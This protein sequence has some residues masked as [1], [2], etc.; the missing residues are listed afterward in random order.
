MNTL[1]KPLLIVLLIGGCTAAKIEKQFNKDQFQIIIDRYGKRISKNSANESFYVAEAYRKSNRIENSAV[2]Y[3][4]AISKGIANESAYIF[5]AKSLKAQEKYDEGKKVI[6]DYLK[7]GQDSVYLD[8]ARRELS[9]LHV[10]DTLIERKTFFR[11]KN[12]EDI[13]T[14]YAEYS[15]VYLKNKLH[16]VSNRG[17]D[18][19]Y[20]SLGVP[21][22]DIFEVE[23]KGAL[24]NKKSLKPM[25][26]VI[27]HPNANEGSMT[28]S[29]D[30]R[31]MIFAKGNTGKSRDVDEVYLYFTRFRNGKWSK[32]KP[33]AVNEPKTWNSCPSLSPN[34]KTLYF[35]SNRIG[36]YG[37][38]DIY[39]ASLDNRGRWVDVRNLG[40]TI[41]TSGNEMFPFL[42]R[43][44]PF[45]FSSNGHPGFGKLDVFIE[46]RK[47][48]K[49][50][51]KNM[52][53]PINSEAD[54]FGIFFFDE[55]RG[56]LA[57]NRKDGKGDDDIYTFVNDDPDLK[58][59]NYFLEGVVVNKID[60]KQ[61]KLNDAKIILVDA[62]GDVL[63]E[64]FSN[65]KGQF[66]F[67]VYEE[68]NYQL[69]TEKDGFF[70]K[71]QAFTTFGKSVDRSTLTKRIN[72]V[73]FD[74][75]IVLDPII[76]DRAIVLKNIYYD[77][78]KA[79][80]RSDAAIELD[81]LVQMLNDNPKISIELGSH[82][83]ARADEVYNMDLSERRAQAAVDYIIGKGIAKEKIVAKGYGESKLIIKD[84][85]NEDEHQ[86]NRRTEFKVIGFLADKLPKEE[87]N[88]QKDESDVSTFDKYF[89]EDDE[90]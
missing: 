76:I 88:T 47:N 77:F 31:T 12:L 68:E 18:K 27:N 72:N 15:P 36:G 19:I 70:T 87:K 48:G 63:D 74:I 10:V 32:P 11:V 78:D 34:G 53:R 20:K 46:T 24:V 69:I 55:V 59:V 90:F 37:G 73:I 79:D 45:Y 35:S 81:K 60:K 65:T 89:D 54:D 75:E 16:F 17:V 86:I 67:R 40:P 62:N 84:A 64:A 13:N 42:S 61:L 6:D 80:I 85:Q 28:F 2:F 71:R 21:F 52:G 29:R 14:S 4:D 25:P 33:L 49:T 83:D 44:G 3:Q 39:S 51:V 58:I 23:S 50:V 22:T 8:L 66:K 82:T 38:T 26:A 9:L 56:F 1:F 41:N 5:L 43:E 7:N 57:S 30:E